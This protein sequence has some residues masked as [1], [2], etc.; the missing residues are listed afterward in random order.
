MHLLEHNPTSVDFLATEQS[1]FAFPP[2]AHEVSEEAR[3][4]MRRY[5][6]L[7]RFTSEFGSHTLAG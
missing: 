6:R 4:L 7:I 5:W 2:E 3:D 1:Q